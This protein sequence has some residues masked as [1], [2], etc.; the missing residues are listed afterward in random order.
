[1]R[2]RMRPGGFGAVL[3]VTHELKSVEVNRNCGG[4]LGAT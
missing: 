4:V 2:P 1:M 3:R